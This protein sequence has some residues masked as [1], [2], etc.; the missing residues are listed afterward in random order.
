MHLGLKDMTTSQRVDNISIHKQDYQSMTSPNNVTK[1]SK[2]SEKSI[3]LNAISLN[4]RNE[5]TTPKCKP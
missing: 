5:L 4:A 3:S 2:S 1:H